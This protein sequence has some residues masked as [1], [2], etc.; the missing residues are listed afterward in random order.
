LAKDAEVLGSDG[1]TLTVSSIVIVPPQL[2]DFI[3]LHA[4]TGLAALK[5]TASHRVMVQR[6]RDAQSSPQTIPAGHLR[7]G[8]PVYCSGGVI[9]PITQIIDSREEASVVQINFHPDSPVEAFYPPQPS[10]LSKGHGHPRT[11]RTQRRATGAAAFDME[12]VAESF[13][14]DD[15]F[16]Y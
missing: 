12:S 7:E 6:G 3:E 2:Q 5:V 15:G 9:L 4:G 13:Y 11:R 14:T 8:D 10:I 16:E 1:Q